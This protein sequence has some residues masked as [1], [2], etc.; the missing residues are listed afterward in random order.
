MEDP[1]RLIR[2]SRIERGWSQTELARAARTSQPAIARLEARRLSPSVS[3]LERIVRALGLRLQLV[4]TEADTAVDRT[5]IAQE[6]RLTPLQ[7]LR[8][9]RSEHD[10]IARMRRTIRPGS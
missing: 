5:L 3:T 9:L 2:E 1:G 10:A 7:R 8:K 4:V 6:L